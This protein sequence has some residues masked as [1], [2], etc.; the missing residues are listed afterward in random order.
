MLVL[1]TFYSCFLLD[2]SS[3]PSIT[4]YPNKLKGNCYGFC[5]NKLP[6]LYCEPSLNTILSQKPVCNP[7]LLS[8][9]NPILYSCVETETQFAYIPDIKSER[10]LSLFTAQRARQVHEPMTLNVCFCYYLFSNCKYYVNIFYF[11]L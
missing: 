10:L 2:I 8:H 11:S 4:L 5:K 7:F 3:S 9:T 6:R 1:D